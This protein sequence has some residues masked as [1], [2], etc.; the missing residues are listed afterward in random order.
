MR[1]QG[2]DIYEKNLEILWA[3]LEMDGSQLCMIG[4]R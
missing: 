3:G 1:E 2:D 4:N